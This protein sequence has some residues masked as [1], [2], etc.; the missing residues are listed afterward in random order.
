MGRGAVRPLLLVALLDGPAH[1]YEIINRL[2][3][4]SRGIWRPSPGTVYP[5]LQMLEEAEVLV[6]HDERG[7]RIYSLTENGR[8]EAER[9]RAIG[10]AK[11]WETATNPEDVHRSD[12]RSAVADLKVAARQV[13]EVAT[14]VQ[15]ERAVAI[16]REA[17]QKLYQ[18]LIDG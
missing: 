3:E 7:K 4:L 1:G 14:A 10:V 2:D 5:T 13:R 8:E 12:F 17:R 16:V 18:L 6:G 9:A 11:R 15:M